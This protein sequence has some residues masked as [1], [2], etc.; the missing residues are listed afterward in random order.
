VYLS[1]PSGIFGSSSRRK[2]ALEPEKNLNMALQ[3]SMT[4]TSW[5]QPKVAALDASARSDLL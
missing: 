5:A 1:L 3:V 2:A 4:E